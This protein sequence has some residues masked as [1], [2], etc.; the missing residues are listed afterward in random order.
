[1]SLPK[2]IYK[3][4][5]RDDT[6]YYVSTSKY[7][8]PDTATTSLEECEKYCRIKDLHRLQDA[9]DKIQLDLV[10]NYGMSYEDIGHHMA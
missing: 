2:R 8:L 4:L 7:F 1:M 10:E 5:K 6:T 9:I 3:P